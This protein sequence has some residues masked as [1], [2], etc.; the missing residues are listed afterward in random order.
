MT[1]Y[2]K[3]LMESKNKKHDPVGKED[4]DINN[5]GEVNS[6][7]SY[8]HNR[9]KVISKNMKSEEIEQIDELSPKTL[10]GYSIASTKNFHKADM[11][12]QSKRMK[13]QKMADEKIRKGEGYSSSAKVGA[14]RMGEEVSIEE[15]KATY[16]GRCGTTHVPPSK[17]GTCPALKNEEVEQIDEL[18]GAK[19]AAY[20]NKVSSQ[21]RDPKHSPTERQKMNRAKGTSLALKKFQG[22]AK[23][24]QPKSAFEEVDLE[25]VLKSSDP[26]SKWIKDFVASDNPKFEGKSK[27]ERIR[28]ALGAKYAKMKEEAERVDEV[29]KDLMLKA[30]KGALDLSKE[31]GSSDAK[32]STKKRNQ[33][34]RFS[35]AA[36]YSG[37]RKSKFNIK[38][39]GM[40]EEAEQIDES[41]LIKAQRRH[42]RAKKEL[43]DAEAFVN[44]SGG[45]GGKGSNYSST[46]VMSAAQKSKHL[47]PYVERHR[48]A[49]Q[50]LA[51]L[52]ATTEEVEQIDELDRQQGS[53][54]NRY[55]SKTNPDYSSPK[56]VKKRAPGRTL[57]LKKKWG[58]KNYGTDEPKVK[59]VQREEVETTDIVQ[60]IANFISNNKDK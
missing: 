40:K 21:I 26:T 9:R 53:I 37:Y 11:K 5:D 55:I 39:A 59:A 50:A 17:G 24:N 23:V 38:P 18:S 6:S 12:T 60:A 8:L 45:T 36:K 47:A 10:M 22:T 52:K 14:K 1:N 46:G 35:N 41:D 15:A 33:S 51:K 34:Y 32:A 31:I 29:T 7:D 13:G 4:S 43:D 48:K 54:L 42:D 56:E 19:L 58:D 30:A 3:I 57:A 16:C 44:S 25:E 2:Y 49:K 28:M 27:K 20:A